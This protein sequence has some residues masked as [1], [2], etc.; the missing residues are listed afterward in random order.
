MCVLGV[1]HQRLCRGRAHVTNICHGDVDI[2]AGQGW[3]SQVEQTHF[4]GRP[5]K[6]AMGVG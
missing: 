5:F 2:V 6:E 4:M 3:Y 1:G